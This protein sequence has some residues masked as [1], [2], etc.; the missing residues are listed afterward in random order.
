MLCIGWIG[1]FGGVYAWLANP[2]LLVA[3]TFILFHRNGRATILLIASLGLALS[4][5]REKHWERDE[6]GMHT[7]NITGYGLGYW[8]WIASIGIALIGCVFAMISEHLGLSSSSR[9]TGT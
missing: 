7:A 4:F 8:L 1:I 2:I 5:L 3:W 9:P 6:S